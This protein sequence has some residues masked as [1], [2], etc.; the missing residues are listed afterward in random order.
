MFIII[1]WVSLRYCRG[2]TNG[3]GKRQRDDSDTDENSK[4]QKI[5]HQVCEKLTFKVQ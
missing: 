5:D 1:L 3:N 2:M 4:K